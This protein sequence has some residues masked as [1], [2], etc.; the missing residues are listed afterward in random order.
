[1]LA[2]D[3]RNTS[4]ILSSV[5]DGLA[6]CLVREFAELGASTYVLADSVLKG[7]SAMRLEANMS[8]REVSFV[9]KAELKALVELLASQRKWIVLVL[10]HGQ[11]FSLD[12]PEVFKVK[13]TNTL[14]GSLIILSDSPTGPSGN[15]ITKSGWTNCWINVGSLDHHRAAKAAAY[16]G[17]PIGLHLTI[18]AS[19]TP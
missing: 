19:V 13:D 16:F 5:N 11:G 9:P 12:L 7:E 2:L 10:N 17:L 6:V 18:Y 8:G 14:L 4:L 3:H 15:Q 1:M